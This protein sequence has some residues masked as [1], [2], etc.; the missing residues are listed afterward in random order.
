MPVHSET[1][2]QNSCQ[3]ATMVLSE[4]RGLWL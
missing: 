4:A 2:K 1:G 3:V